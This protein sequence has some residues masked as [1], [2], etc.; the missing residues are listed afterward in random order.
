MQD[1]A[2]D[3]SSEAAAEVSED[4]MERLE[5]LVC[6]ELK[7]VSYRWLSRELSIPCNLAKQLLYQFAK[8]KGSDVYTSYMLGGWTKEQ[9]RRHVLQLVDTEHLQDAQSKL[10]PVTCLHVYSVHPTA[11]K[12][13]ADLWAADYLQTETLFKKLPEED[14]CLRDNR[15]SAVVCQSVKRVQMQPG[16]RTQ[17]PTAPAPGTTTTKPAAAAVAAAVPSVSNGKHVSTL[18][19]TPEKPPAVAVPKGDPTKPAAKA[20]GSKLQSMWTKPPPSKPHRAAKPALDSDAAIRAREA[21]EAKSE[22]DSQEEEIFAKRKRGSGNVARKRQAA[23]ADS[24]PGSPAK[25]S[26]ERVTPTPSP[27][28]CAQPQASPPDVE[29]NGAPDSGLRMM[30]VDGA[31]QPRS[32]ARDDALPSVEKRR[33]VTKTYIDD[34]GFEVTE[35]VWEGGEEP[36]S[37]PAASEPVVTN[38]PVKPPQP[39]PPPPPPKPAPAPALRPVD[40]NASKARAPVKRGGKAAPIKGQGSITSFFSRKT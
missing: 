3:L 4:V 9:D 13:S 33:K 14:N 38:E 27:V 36:V 34:S 24:P 12:D 16:K 17:K 15:F 8:Q 40:T 26:P 30:E 11:P 35:M 22:S 18:V 2:A 31:A 32:S 6:E 20:G 37:E 19:E 25:S 21:E 23:I 7:T 1:A 39:S 5:V 29:D 28:M 10:E